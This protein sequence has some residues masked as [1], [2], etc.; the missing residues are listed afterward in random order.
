[1]IFN[2]IPVDTDSTFAANS[3]AKVASQKATKTAVD[4]KANI[5]S[6]TLTGTPAAP[7]A[8]PADNSTKIAT[9]AYVD[10]AILGQR[11]KE[12]VKFASIAAL[13]AIVYANGS[14]G[15]G[16]TL[17]GVA[18]GALGI[19][20]GSPAVAD[21][22]LIKN[23]AST[24][25][26]GIYTVT[27][28][29]SGIAVFVLTRATDFDQA[30]D[31]QTGDSVFVTAGS[32]LANTTWAFNGIDSPA[33]G[34]D[35]L[36]FVQSAGVGVN[37][38]GNGIT[39]TG[40]SIAIDTSVTVDKTTAQVLTNKD[41][42]SGTNTFPTL[43]QNTT[44]SAA[45]WTTA[46]NLAGNSVDG[47]GAVAFANKFVVQ[48]TADAGLSAAQFMGASDTGI[49]KNT[50]TTGVLS[51]A[52][53]SDLPAMSATVGGAV[54]TPPNNTTTYL[55][56]DG[57]FATVSASAATFNPNLQTSS[58]NQTVPLLSTIFL[59]RKYILTGTAQCINHG[60]II[61]KN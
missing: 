11:L 61:N 57:T 43:N 33:M 14:S 48:G 8:T 10:N 40:A 12:A 55:R 36:T 44:G 37:T 6:P 31:I 25:Q 28:T 7:T 15:V 21:R 50:T 45:K 58:A 60:Q 49:V 53:N 56:G 30:S 4:L 16:A 39:I 46:R 13:P 34:S 22:V 2:P 24:F 59:F 54:P 29:G 42:S 27:A 51:I 47:S 41:L 18:F 19:D 35:A 32:T 52:V 5:A 38:A 26:N 9:T 3:D 23:Q 20:S 1:M 17:T